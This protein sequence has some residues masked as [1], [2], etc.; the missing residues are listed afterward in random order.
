M[1]AMTDSS[2]RSSTMS[3]EQLQLQMERSIDQ[4]G[5][6]ARSGIEASQF[7]CEVLHLA[8]HPGGASRAIFWR[9]NST[10]IWQP[11]GH[12]PGPDVLSPVEIEQHQPVV[13][14]VVQ[15]GR[16]QLVKGPGELDVQWTPMTVSGKTVAVLETSHPIE[17]ASSKVI[18]AQFLTALA[19]VAADFLSQ[20]ELQQL[21]LARGNW[22]QW[23]QYV[24]RL[25]QSLDLPTVCSVLVNDGRLLVD[26]DRVSVLVRRG[27][28]YS[29]KSITGV[30]RIEPRSTATQSIEMMSQLAAP[31][32]H[33]VWSHSPSTDQTELRPVELEV[34]DHLSQHLRDAGASCAGLI[35]VIARPIN[36]ELSAPTAVIMF[37]QFRPLT[38]METWQTRAEA[39]VSRSQPVLLSAIERE[40]IPWIG[41]WQR[42]RSWPRQIGKPSTLLALALLSGLIAALTL[43]P[44]K[45]TVSGPA[46]LWPA[47]RRE[48]FASTSGLIDQILV[49]H[50]ETVV[51][52]QPLIVLRDPELEAETPRILGEIATVNERLK[53]VQAARLT[54]GNTPDA[55]SR[56]RQLTVDEEELKERL[57]TLEQQH[58]QLKERQAAL[59]LRSPIAGQILTW[60]VV[61]Q[62]SARP[63]ERG[64]SLLAIGETSGPWI[65]E[66]QLPDKEIGHM[67]QA[68]K[69]LKP[70][71]DV[72]FLLPAE[73]EKIYH[74]H[75]ERRSLIVE[76]DDDARSQVRVV[77]AIDP[78]QLDQ[79]RPGATALPRIHCGSR[80]VG[81]VWLRDLIDAIRTRLLF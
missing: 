29:L 2:R 5:E 49:A 74:G 45:F 34:R 71:L 60:D 3:P 43:I 20:L 79:P 65:V 27:K 14:S 77:A 22:Q 78:D 50:G 23:D 62:L 21:R 75:I 18:T 37:E 30:D 53:G 19:E 28:G 69:T 16:P 46:T 80:S 48:V 4:L 9:P 67:I 1:N 66:I 17:P 68:Q 40:E 64:Q 38:D 61:Q 10:D 56:A 63:V 32:R 73:P 36:G 24:Q 47:Q 57:R 76:A 54:G 70:D 52:N 6:L 11:V 35:P 55:T 72:E 8:Q 33:P 15:S 12:V 41:L 58:Q 25:W 81:Y 26:C 39:L 7:I 42:T 59:T 44:A 31:L 13:V 51:A